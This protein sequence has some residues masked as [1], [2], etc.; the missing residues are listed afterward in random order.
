MLNCSY[1]DELTQLLFLNGNQEKVHESALLAIERYGTPR[2]SEAHDRLWIAFDSG[3][4]AQ[5]LYLMIKR[6]KRDQLIGA[7]VYTRHND[8]L[9][10]LYVAVLEEYAFGEIEAKDAVFFR[11]LDEI[12]RIARS[13]RGISSIRLFL[14]KPPIDLPIRR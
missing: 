12:R 4:E 3:I 6:P 1:Q 2:I 14:K 9:D 8:R 10:V 7:F 13:I 11:I 5:S